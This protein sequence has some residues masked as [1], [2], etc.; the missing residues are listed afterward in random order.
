MSQGDHEMPV[1]PLMALTL[2]VMVSAAASTAM[3]SP[4]MK[5]DESCVQVICT[6]LGGAKLARLLTF[7]T[8]TPKLE[9]TKLEAC[10]PE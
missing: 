9:L 1:G 7:H 6:T 3:T 4:C 2:T 5:S 10:T 8:L